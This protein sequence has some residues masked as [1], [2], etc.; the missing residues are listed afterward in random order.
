VPELPDLVY[1]QQY[2]GRT[3]VGKRVDAVTVR[4][5]VVLRNATDRSPEEVLVERRIAGVSTKAPFLCFAF[6]RETELIINLMLAG[7]LQHRR[8]GE[9]SIGHVCLSIALDDGSDLTLSDPEG[10]RGYDVF[11]CPHCQP[12]TRRHFINWNNT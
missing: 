5:P 9:K 2:L 11:F 10:V 3:I 8:A 4:E 1:I 7:T 12:A 6:D